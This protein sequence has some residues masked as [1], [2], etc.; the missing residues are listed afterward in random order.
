[1]ELGHGIKPEKVD[2]ILRAFSVR[3]GE[4]IL[5]LVK[6]NSFRPMVDLVVVTTIRL[7]MVSTA[8][9]S[10]DMAYRALL[11]EIVEATVDKR[12]LTVT[13]TDGRTVKVTLMDQKD[14]PLLGELLGSVRATPPSPALAAEVASLGTEVSDV[15]QVAEGQDYKS[16]RKEADRARKEA[17]KAEAAEAL[18]RHYES[19]AE[20]YGDRVESA[21]FGGKAVEIY[22]K[23]YVRVAVFLTKNTA[24]ERLVSIESSAN[25]A[26]KSAAGRAAGAVL[27]AGLNLY[28]SNKRGDAFLTIMTD[29]RA[30]VLHEDPPTAMGLRNSKKL[31]AAGQAVITATAD[32]PAASAPPIAARTVGVRERLQQLSELHSDGL[33]T[34][35]DFEAKKAQ[36]LAEL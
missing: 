27:T 7:L 16:A 10:D 31:E 19:I 15:L 13:T 8:S 6:C 23:G 24:F 22:S 32:A 17:A 11:S 5:A 28:A 25:V 30:I 2:K 18:E 34:D 3:E 26:K 9:A 20:N 29:K 36:L 21:S 12:S 14:V 33:I 4:D 1:M 35:A